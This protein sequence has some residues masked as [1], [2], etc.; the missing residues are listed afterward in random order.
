MMIKRYFLAT[1]FAVFLLSMLC[2]AKESINIDKAIGETAGFVYETVKEPTVS[3]IGGEWVVL[4]LSRSGVEVPDEYYADYYKRV[5]EYV[6]EKK[7]VLHTKKY[8]EYSR[9]ILAL[10]S[11]GKKPE[12]VAGYNL[13]SPLGDYEKTIW[14]GI[15]GPVFALIALDCKNYDIPKNKDAKTQATREM[16]VNYILKKQLSD[17]G[18]ALT[19]SVSDPDVTAMVLQAL[20]NYQNNSK[21]KTAT[22]KALI[23][24]SNM[25]NTNGGFST[26]G[27]ETSESSVQ[28]LVALCSLGIDPQDS[29]FVKNGKSVLDSVLS[30]SL[31]GGAFCHTKNGATNLMATEQALYGLVAYK[32]FS[33]GKNSLYSM[34]DA[35]SFTGNKSVQNGLKNKHK[36]IKKK[37][38]IY[39]G[40][41]FGDISSLKT[42]EKIEAL[43]SRGIING[44]TKDTFD[45]NGK[46]TRA[47]FAT[48]TIKSLGLSEKSGSVFSDVKKND[49]FYG[50]VYSA[51]NYGIIKG[52][53]ENRFSPNGTITREEA[54]VMIMR[55][56][57]LCGMNTELSK[58]EVRNILCVFPDYVKASDWSQNALAFCFKEGIMSDEVSL[59]NPKESVTR[60]EIAELLYNLLDKAKLL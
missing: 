35:I 13:L 34:G 46:M 41:T 47:E 19:G 21:V 57:S 31:E 5:E 14:Q 18:W 16:Y 59:I 36:D 11:I 28:V 51:F 48:I 49:W 24:L 10:S 12:N 33:E 20:S 40:K 15:N 56:A 50:Y 17:G 52:V 26:F 54:A 42:K 37:E 38:I 3:S 4:G 53:S 9:V 58:S 45:P 1:I 25:Q 27:Q 44:K 32:R 60:K 29:R 6:K 2:F 7:G 23:C 39:V 8:T 55:S 30:Y 43:I 22:S